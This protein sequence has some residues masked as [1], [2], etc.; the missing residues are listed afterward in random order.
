M[1]AKD[2]YFNV[3]LFIMMHKGVLSFRC[4]DEILVSKDSNG[5]TFYQYFQVVP[6]FL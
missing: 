5:K 6:C 4:L 3:V 1:K 2:Q